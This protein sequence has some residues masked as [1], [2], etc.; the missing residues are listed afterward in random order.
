MSTTEEHIAAVAEEIDALINQALE[1]I[2]ASPPEDT[3]GLAV[4]VQVGIDLLGEDAANVTVAQF[5]P[6]FAALYRNV[7]GSLNP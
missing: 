4:A 3:V 5:F 7:T 2:V 1:R 6:L